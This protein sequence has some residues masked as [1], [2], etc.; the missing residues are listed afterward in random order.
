VS[1]LGTHDALVG[2]DR[3]TRD[4]REV[5]AAARSGRGRIIVFAGEPGIGRTHLLEH[6][7][8][9][10]TCEGVG[11]VLVRCYEDD[12]REPHTL[13]RAL[14]RTLGEGRLANGV[15]SSGERKAAAR[16]ADRLREVLDRPRDRG[17]A[18]FI[19]DL[20]W[21]DAESVLELRNIVRH[22]S[23]H[24]F[25]IVATLRTPIV[26]AD[27]AVKRFI[28]GIE[29]DR[30]GHYRRL[31]RLNADEVTQLIAEHLSTQP[32][33][34]RPHLVTEVARLSEGVPSY[35][36][37][38]LRHWNSCGSLLHLPD[39]Q[40][41][42]RNDVTRTLPATFHVDMERQLM[43]LGPDARFVAEVIAVLGERAYRPV[44]DQVAAAASDEARD[45]AAGLS[46]LVA[47]GIATERATTRTSGVV[48]VTVF[49]H[50]LIREHVYTT[51]CD[52]RRS[53]MHAAC[54][55]VLEASRAAFTIEP[56]ELAYH[57]Q[58]GAQ[59]PRAVQYAWET[60][61]VSAASGDTAA[62]IE[63]YRAVIAL[64][65]A[66][67][68]AVAN[69]EETISRRVA[70]LLAIERLL[71]RAG[72]TQQRVVVLST[73]ETLLSGSADHR[74]DFRLALRRSRLELQRGNVRDARR[75]A[76][77]AL[78]LAGDDGT[79]RLAA[80]IAA[81]EARTGRVIGEPSPLMRP[82]ADLRAA[83]GFYR[84]AL[85]HAQSGGDSRATA[86]ML[87]ELGVIHWSLRGDGDPQRPILAR[88]HVMAALDR[89]RECGD[90]G[91][92]VTALIALAYQR[93]TSET[94]EAVDVRESYVSFLEEIR[95]LRATQHRLTRPEDRPRIDALAMLS[96]HLFCRVNGWY[97]VAIDRASRAHSWAERA[98][99]ERIMLLASAGLSE[100][101]RLVGRGPRALEHAESAWAATR[102]GGHSAGLLAHQEAVL[103]ALALAHAEAGVPDLAVS[104]VHTRL[105]LA[106]RGGQRAAV[107]ESWALMAEVLDI[108]GQHA[109]ASRAAREALDAASGLPGAI[110]SDIRTELVLARAAMQRADTRVAVGHA[111][112]ARGRMTQRGIAQIALK[113]QV[114]LVRGDALA[115]AGFDE[116]ARVEIQRAVLLVEQ[117]AKRISDPELRESF[118]TR[119][120]I[121]QQVRECASRLGIAVR[122]STPQRAERPGNLTRREIE[123]LRL[124]ASGSANRDIADELFISEKTVARHLTNIFTK[125]GIQSR[126]QAAA[127]A[128]RNGIA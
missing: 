69:A 65:D 40:R 116:D 36:V 10:L 11:C 122:V 99:D 52:T 103:T 123:I 95:R 38:L 121:P 22:T 85:E 59:F 28:E 104:H 76:D 81:A 64:Y 12:G 29:R 109:P 96:I 47:H 110:T 117:V 55:V 26:A 42:L 39:G 75:D 5:A 86:T 51:M 3:E 4:I 25:S 112:A 97:D 118:L 93:D 31:E 80:L 34:L 108:L 37:E 1:S 107:A 111:T 24:S 18:M 63:D 83:E 7:R 90:R 21:A 105:D 102:V 20:Q 124:V 101:E 35:A 32:A 15:D 89:F 50:A 19:D 77:R 2:R 126:T 92:E 17:L 78:Q 66:L 49:S 56:R 79:S 13:I 70:A 94:R 88:Q 54:G 33:L 82:E 9:T 27:P 16:L 44:L 62:A 57:F 91:G 58:R 113:M 46:E 120:R 72:D 119:G 125:L 114:A 6:G 45:L 48:S 60:A 115:L 87:Q 53:E 100:V 68:D 23:E 30:L 73:I 128:Y 106:V 67:P 74:L 43:G 84:Q 98:R 71:E 61:E 8:D 41:E 14:L 127:W